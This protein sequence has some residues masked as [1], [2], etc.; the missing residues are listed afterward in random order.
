MTRTIDETGRD[1]RGGRP[2]A[3]ELE[4]RDE[5]IL[6][7]AGETF[8]N[9]GFGGTTMDAVAGA[10]GISKRT[11]YARY[12]DKTVLFNAV[13]RDLIDRWLSTIEHFQTESGTLKDKLL[14]LGRFL[15]E[16]TLTP[17]SVGV[18][19]IIICEAQRQSEFG[20]LVNEAGRK[21][22]IRSVVSILRQHQAELRSIDLEMAAEQFLSLAVDRNLRLAFRGLSVDVEQWVRTSVDL[23]LAGV[24]CHDACDAKR[25]AGSGPGI[26]RSSVRHH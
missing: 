23:F 16:T 25:V 10:A 8:L 7:V 21:P 5:H 4:Q 2:K 13:L 3:T 24:Q 17:R 14:S 18:N 19:R 9:S 15:V 26:R 11:L 6:R 20:H 12:A 1:G 22:A